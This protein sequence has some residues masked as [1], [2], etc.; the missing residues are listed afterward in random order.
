MLGSE[1][2]IPT[3]SNQKSRAW[4]LLFIVMI[5]VM[6]ACLGMQLSTLSISKSLNMMDPYDWS[7]G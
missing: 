1:E 6:L 7:F 5:A 3:Q 4:P 2:R